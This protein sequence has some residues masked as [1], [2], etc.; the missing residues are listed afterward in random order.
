[1]FCFKCCSPLQDLDALG[2]LKGMDD[3]QN[4]PPQLPDL[5]PFP[6]DVNWL[7]LLMVCF[8]QVPTSFDADWF[9]V[10]GAIDYHASQMEIFF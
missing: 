4:L 9:E 2:V 7:V 5:E 1:M 6:G 3:L 10:S 8:F